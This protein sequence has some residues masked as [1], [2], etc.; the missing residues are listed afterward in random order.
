MVIGLWFGLVVGF[1]FVVDLLGA[2]SEKYGLSIL[3]ELNIS[4]S[5]IQMQLFSMP[6]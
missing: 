4:I 6:L 5:S 3:L 2:N 1:D